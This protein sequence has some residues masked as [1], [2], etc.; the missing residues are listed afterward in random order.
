MYNFFFVFHYFSQNIVFFFINK[1]LS[2]NRED[3]F[4]VSFFYIT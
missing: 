1:F 4:F 2:M 3:L